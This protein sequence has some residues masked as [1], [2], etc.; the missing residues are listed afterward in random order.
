MR[1]WFFTGLRSRLILLVLLAVIPTWGVVFYNAW[2]Q[3]RIATLDIQNQIARLADFNT[4]VDTEV[5]EQTRQI[6]LTMAQLQHKEQIDPGEWHSFLYRIIKGYNPFMNLGIARADGELISCALPL[7]VVNGLVKG[8]W[9]DAVLKKRSFFVDSH[10]VKDINGKEVLPVALPV[11]DKQGRVSWVVF[12][13]LDWK[14]MNRFKFDVR[15][16][17]P[18]GSTI[19]LT[20]PSGVI[21]DRQPPPF[22]ESSFDETSLIRTVLKKK[23]GVVDAGGPGGIQYLYVFAPV[24][25]YLRKENNYLILGVPESTAFAHANRMLN[26]NLV[27]IAVVALAAFLISWY[28]G[29]FSILRRVKALVKAAEGLAAGDLTARTGL[30]SGHGELSQLAHTFDHMATSLENREAERRQAE[31]AL[32]SSREE[33]RNLSIHLQ[34]LAEEERTHIAREIH[35]ELGQTLT[36]LKFDISWLNSRLPDDGDRRSDGPVGRESVRERL[37]SMSARIDETLQTVHRVSTE[38]RPGLLDDFG[39]Q[40]AMEWQAEEFQNRTGVSCA[41]TFKPEQI[42]MNREQSTAVFRIFQETLT[43]VARHAQATKVEVKLTETDGTVT[44]EVEDNG[45]GITDREIYD[46]RSFGLIGMR[47]RASLWGG[48]VHIKGQSGRGTTVIVTIPIE[49]GGA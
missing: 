27:I 28:W 10:Q 11:L 39:L 17:M 38:L 18:Q 47:E 45:R 6:L 2:E 31:E 37:H 49:A 24:S 32:Q 3:R 34:T 20:D 46:H 9:F 22:A 44:L 36:A 42:E 19:T 48:T 14:W 30:S 21:L 25:S 12:A 15:T 7:Q 23:N 35:D 29:E 43:N 1:R 26:R 16:Q 13:F 8:D 5:I 41:L 33:L 4:R 40:A